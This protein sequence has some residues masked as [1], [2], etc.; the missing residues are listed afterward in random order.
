MKFYVME[1]IVVSV[2][3]TKISKHSVVYNLSIHE[4]ISGHIEKEAHPNGPMG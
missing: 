3:V 4:T 2:Y 1:R